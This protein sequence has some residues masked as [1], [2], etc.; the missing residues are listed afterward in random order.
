M[1]GPCLRSLCRPVLVVPTH[2]L[3][4][5]HV[6]DAPPAK[7][8]AYAPGTVPSVA[9][10]ADELLGEPLLVQQP[11]GLECVEHSL[12]RI[13]IGA[14]AGELAG[15][16]ATRVLAACEQPESPRPQLRILF[17]GQ[18]STASPVAAVTFRPGRSRSR[19]AVSMEFAT[20]LFSFR[21][22]RTLSRP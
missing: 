10:R 20:S 6:V 18:A 4:G 7:V 15:K 5:R 1:P 8:V 14:A 19:N 21:K 13:R 16:F 12:Y 17:V 22:S 11:P 2:C 3:P 9:P